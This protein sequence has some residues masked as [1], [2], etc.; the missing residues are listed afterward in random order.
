[1]PLEPVD[2]PVSLTDLAYARLRAAIL[3]GSM[4]P[5][6]TISVVAAADALNMS[7]SPVRSAVERLTGELLARQV[8]AS[9]VVSHMSKADLLATLDVRAPLE[10]LAAELAASS[11]GAAEIESLEELHSL[12]AGAVERGDSSAAREADFAFHRRVREVAA[13]EVLT[14]HLARLEARIMLATY[15]TAWRGSQDT[16]VGEHR[17]ILDAIVR[18]D[19]AGA[20]EAA[21]V[22]VASARS[23]AAVGWD[24]DHR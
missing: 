3:D 23:R 18:H 14:E 20:G 22:H 1:M 12:F 6:T 24:E 11:S 13:N 2:R 4:P 7:R 17:T 8:G 19:E 9:V 10:G 16:A 15:V 5:G 21:R